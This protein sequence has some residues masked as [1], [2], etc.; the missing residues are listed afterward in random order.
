MKLI[1]C[2]LLKLTIAFGVA[3]G[4]LDSS[5]RSIEPSSTD[6]DRGIDRDAIDPGRE[7]A[8]KGEIL[9]PAREGHHGF[10][11]RIESILLVADD[12]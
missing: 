1:R 10:L 12:A 3:D 2:R 7:P 6:I 4:G 5:A 8:A 9:D 11:R